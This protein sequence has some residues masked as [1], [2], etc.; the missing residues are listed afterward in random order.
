MLAWTRADEY[1]LSITYSMDQLPSNDDARS[2]CISPSYPPSLRHVLTHLNP[3]FFKSTTHPGGE[4]AVEAGPED[5]E[6]DGSD[7]GRHVRDVA[8][9]VLGVRRPGRHRRHNKRR[10]QAVICTKGVNCYAAAHVQATK[11]LCA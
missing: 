5:E 2:A 9:A 4:R 11:H 8:G 6:E 1:I 10:G 3:F 7:H